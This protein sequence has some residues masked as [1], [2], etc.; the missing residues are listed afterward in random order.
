[1]GIKLRATRKAGKQRD[2]C[3]KGCCPCSGREPDHQKRALG[4]PGAEVHPSPTWTEPIGKDLPFRPAS[5]STT[6]TNANICLPTPLPVLQPPAGSMNRGRL[7]GTIDRNHDGVITWDEMEQALGL[8]SRAW[9]GR[10]HHQHEFRPNTHRHTRTRTFNTPSTPTYIHEHAAST[11]RHTNM[12]PQKT[13]SKM[14]LQDTCHH[15]H[16]TRACAP[17]QTHH[18]TRTTQHLPTHRSSAATILKNA[19]PFQHEPEAW[20]RLRVLLL[21]S[22]C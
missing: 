10:R 22:P 1:M 12:H 17:R 7:F 2:C 14:H 9:S 8:L 11:H 13:N 6:K 18:H 19:E 15:G 16:T 3:L 20:R 4:L 5:F 21:C